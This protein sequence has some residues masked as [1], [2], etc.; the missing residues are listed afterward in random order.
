MEQ[1]TIVEIAEY[2][3]V[4]HKCW[5]GPKHHYF[6][7]LLTYVIPETMA[8]RI[9]QAVSLVASTYEQATNN[10]KVRYKMQGKAKSG[11]AACIKG[12]DSKILSSIGISGASVSCWR[13]VSEMFCMS[14]DF[15]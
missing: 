5:N 4:W 1:P 9:P 11:F 8:Q 13:I 3:L 10:L 15:Y 2:K 7:H 12:L 6:P 14:W